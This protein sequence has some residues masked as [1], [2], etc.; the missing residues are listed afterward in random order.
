MED[1]AQVKL[2]KIQ[3]KKQN[4]YKYYCRRRKHAKIKKINI[5]GNEIFTDEELL[6]S[7]ELSEGSFFSFLSN[8]NQYSRESLLET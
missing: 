6:D 5:I 2:K 8:N 4:R 3:T 7:F 1:M